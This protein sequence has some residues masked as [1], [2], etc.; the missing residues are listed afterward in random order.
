VGEFSVF[1]DGEFGKD[2]P[3]GTTALNN[4]WTPH[5]PSAAVLEMAREAELKPQKVDH[6]KI[7]LVESRFPVQL[8]TF[9]ETVM[10][11]IADYADHWNGFVKRFPS[12]LARGASTGG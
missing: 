3:A 9:A 2:I 7:L 1:L 10:P 5:G 11:E 8:T 12:N 6:Q 4:G